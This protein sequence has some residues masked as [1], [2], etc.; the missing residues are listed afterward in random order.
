MMKLGT[1]RS[2]FSCKDQCVDWQIPR[3]SV[4]DQL[5]SLR[6]Q[7]S[8]HPLFLCDAI[9]PIAPNRRADVKPI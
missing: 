5:E 4:N 9:E 6:Q 3:L 8:E 7:R 1:Q 2:I